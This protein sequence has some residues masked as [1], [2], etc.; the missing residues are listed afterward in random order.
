M[1]IRARQICTFTISTF[2]PQELTISSKKNAK[3]HSKH[4]AVSAVK[5]SRWTHRKV[6]RQPDVLADEFLLHVLKGA[7]LGLHVLGPV[8][9]LLQQAHQAVCL[10]GV[11]V[12]DVHGATV[13]L[14]PDDGVRVAELLL[15]GVVVALVHVG[16]G[17]REPPQVVAALPQQ[18]A[19][20]GHAALAQVVLG[21]L[22]GDVAVEE[23]QGVHVVGHFGD[24]R[25]P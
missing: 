23:G 8:A 25:G 4:H 1:I 6:P 22:A 18:V 2:F 17:E 19:A 12:D 16:D 7:H 5:S 21:L 20:V 9:G 15:D 24:G 10:L 14:A 11:M 13:A 3:K